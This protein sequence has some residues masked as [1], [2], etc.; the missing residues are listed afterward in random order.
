MAKQTPPLNSEQAA[1]ILGLSRATINRQAA[2]GNIPATKLPGR[3]GAFIF[4]RETIESLA[5]DRAA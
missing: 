5:L 1:E 2:A 4:D 3:T